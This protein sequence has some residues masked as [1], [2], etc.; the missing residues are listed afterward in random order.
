MRKRSFPNRCFGVEFEVG[1][2]IGPHDIAKML[3]KYSDKKVAVTTGWAQSVNNDF[4]HVKF[5]SSCGVLK[6]THGWEVASF[7]AS[8]R[9]HLHHIGQMARE[10]QHLGCEINANCGYH[11]HC[12]VKDYSPSKM[13]VLLARWLKIEPFLCKLV[14]LMRIGNY[15]CKLLNTHKKLK[16]GRR[17]SASALWKS[18]RPTNFS[19]HE[20]DQKKVTLNTVSFAAVCKKEFD[21]DRKT[22][23]FRM[24]EGTLDYDDVVNWVRFFVN[25]VESS[26]NQKMPLNLLPVQTMDGFLKLA[27]LKSSN[28]FELDED[29][30]ET[31]KWVFKRLN[32]FNLVNVQTIN[33]I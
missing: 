18:L 10:L 19:P 26:K 9:D 17:Y 14:P 30:E 4:W 28:L 32:Q 31:K 15:Y 6:G 13:G 8:G 5:D 1:A 21:K 11:I 20:N 27:G 3:M 29:L 25:F 23:E 22:I 16:S 2:E 7:K 33:S 24:P 12:E